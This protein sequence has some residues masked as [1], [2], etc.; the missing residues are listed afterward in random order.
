M[1][2]INQIKHGNSTSGNTSTAISIN[3]TYYIWFDYFGSDAAQSNGS[4]HLYINTS[5]TKPE[6]PECTMTGEAAEYI[7]DTAYIGFGGTGLKLIM[8]H[9]LLDN[10]DLGTIDD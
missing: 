1:S 5:N 9:F 3:T 4:A 10:S 8:D 2:I 7:P 6:T